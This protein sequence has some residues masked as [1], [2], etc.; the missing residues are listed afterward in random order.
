MRGA[1]P[2]LLPHAASSILRSRGVMPWYFSTSFATTCI[3]LPSTLLTMR[4][5]KSV[6]MGE[7]YITCR[8]HLHYV[9]QD[10]DAWG[11]CL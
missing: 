3:R 9:L 2:P 7:C 10:F 4:V 8:Q 1:L 11:E 5:A 6:C